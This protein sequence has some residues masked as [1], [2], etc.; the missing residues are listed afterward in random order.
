MS[1]LGSI[2]GFLL[3]VAFGWILFSLIFTIIMPRQ[4]RRNTLLYR[5]CVWVTLIYTLS[6]MCFG[7]L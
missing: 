5:I 2:V 6:Q 3:A 1:I 4:S 7:C